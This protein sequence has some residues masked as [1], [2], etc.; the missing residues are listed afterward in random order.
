MGGTGLTL[1][2]LQATK[3]LLDQAEVDPEAPRYLV[4]AASQIDT[5]LLSTTEVKSADYNSIR[6]LVN[7]TVDTFMGFKF[8]RTELLTKTTT[9]RYCYAYAK[10]AIGMGV[11]SDLQSKIDQR[12]DK[13]YAWQ[14]WDKMDMGA[15]RVEEVQVVEIA[16]YEA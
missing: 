15:T 7:G 4:C 3:Q 1:A 2:K 8:I 12:S 9:T 11:L 10:G 13:N 6:A 16:C 5:D 14:V